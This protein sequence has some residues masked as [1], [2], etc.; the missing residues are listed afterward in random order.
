MGEQLQKKTQPTNTL[1]KHDEQYEKLNKMECTHE[2]GS[3]HVSC[4]N[5]IQDVYKKL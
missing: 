2:E 4:F 5:T 1:N 3:A